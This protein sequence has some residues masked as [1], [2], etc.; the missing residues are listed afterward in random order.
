MTIK[1]LPITESSPLS[2]GTGSRWEISNI[3]E[4]VTRTLNRA[5]SS[6]A[7]HEA[8]SDY[9]VT[10][11]ASNDPTI[12]IHP[13][14][15]QNGVLVS[16][17]PPIN[18]QDVSLDHVPCDI[19]L[20]IDIS[21]S[22]SFR[23]PW[24]D[25]EG[26]ERQHEQRP[27][28]MEIAKHAA[29]TI[30]K[31]LDETD[32][33][34]IVTFGDRADVLQKL[35]PMTKY[36]KTLSVE[37]IDKIKTAGTTNMWGGIK[38][39]LDLFNDRSAS[40]Q[41]KVP[42]ILVLTDG[43][44]N[45][46]NPPDDHWVNAI[47]SMGALKASIHTF[48]FGNQADSGVLKSVAEVGNGNYSFISDAGLV[49]TIFSHAVANLQSTFAN[50]CFLKLTFPASLTLEKTTGKTLEY[51]EESV[52]YAFGNDSEPTK[53]IVLQVGNLHYGQSQD[54][55]FRYSKECLEQLKA[56]TIKVGSIEAQFT[57]SLLGEVDYD[58]FA[59]ADLGHATNLPPS[60]IDYHI[61]RSLICEY[62]SSLMRIQPGGKRVTDPYA[63]LEVA[64]NALLAGLPARHHDDEANQSLIDDVAGQIRIGSNNIEFERWGRHFFPSLWTAHAK[65]IRNSFK[66][67][68]VQQYNKRSP[69]F[70][71]CYTRL[72]DQY[73]EPEY[74][75]REN[76]TVQHI[77][78]ASYNNRDS[79]CFAASA[80]VS[81]A[82]GRKIPIRRLRK[83]AAV[84]TPAGPR[85][86]SA[87]LKTSVT[88]VLLCK[89]G[90]LLVT[91]WHPIKMDSNEEWLFPV[92]AAQVGAVRY[93]GC[94][95]SVLL[96]RDSDIN[97]HAICVDGVWGVTMGHGIISGS[98]V[99]AHEFFGDYIQVTKAMMQLDISS[100]GV[101]RASG[102]KRSA[103]TGRMCGFKKLSQR[104]KV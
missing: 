42:V 30:T 78:W 10:T 26:R 35:T 1:K 64:F 92:D 2:Q 96:Q 12:A 97:A 79:S 91:P 70:L 39:G 21:G 95:Y 37:A 29:S 76:G 11:I 102:V 13:L 69:L 53:T 87:V 67:P 50:K 65:Q 28:I 100:N 57:F 72:S 86:V 38:S 24:P 58:I 75:R 85:R 74:K 43:H 68:G 31:S 56:G 15:S 36:N 48:G 82:G 18:P 90:R 25:T 49:G 33:L 62:L 45:T 52:G 23:P 34:G 32:R 20:V 47:R 94:V 80:L 60:I 81:L 99:R 59:E 89:V 104:A 27:S 73:S 98:D 84:Q 103:T 8:A 51:Y 3:S 40:S 22:M 88:D 63:D 9:S 14:S 4:M 44:S 19:V 93:S 7:T 6:K 66:D 61:S 46:G 101:A 17:E 5:T 55:Y 83:G 54:I 71:R 77:H 16:V 41:G